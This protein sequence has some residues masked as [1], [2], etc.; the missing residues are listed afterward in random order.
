MVKTAS[1]SEEF[2]FCLFE[3]KTNASAIMIPGPDAEKRHQS[4]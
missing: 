4:S 1:V 2:H 3:S